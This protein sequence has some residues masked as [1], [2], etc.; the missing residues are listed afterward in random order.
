MKEGLFGILRRCLAMV[1]AAVGLGGAWGSLA[2]IG[3]KLALGLQE[4]HAWLFVGLPVAIVVVLLMW[5]RLP[6]L[7]RF[8][9]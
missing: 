9:Q 3:A 1:A 6:R 8:E 5:K 7:L 2:A 4:V